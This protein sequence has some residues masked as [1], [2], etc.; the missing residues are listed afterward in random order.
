MTTIRFGIALGVVLAVA[1]PVLAHHPF[2]VEF[3]WKKPVTVSGV[4]TKFDWENPHAYL[5][6]NVQDSEGMT[7][8]WNFEMGSLSALRKAG[9]TKETL[10]PGD[11]VSIDG[12]RARSPSKPTTANMKTIRLPNGRELSGASSAGDA[13]PHERIEPKASN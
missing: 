7:R 2:P 10:K 5:R 1:L 12:W 11:K 9:W 8:S 4:V 13:E 6:I 3:D